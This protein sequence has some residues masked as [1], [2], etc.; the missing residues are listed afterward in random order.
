MGAILVGAILLVLVQA[1]VDGR[2]SLGDAAIAI[3]ALQQLTN[4]LRTA[5]SASGS[6]RQSSLFLDDYE[7][8]RALRTSTRSAQAPIVPRAHG[9][10]AVEHVSFRYPGTD[11]TVLDDVSLELRQARSS[12]R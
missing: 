9:W 11:V 6:L 10:L 7:R 4:Q 2:I 8:F 12:R 1:A 3:V 5:A